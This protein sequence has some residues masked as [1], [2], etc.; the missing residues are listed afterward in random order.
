MFVGFAIDPTR[1]SEPDQI[2]CFDNQLL[3]NHM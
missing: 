1:I 3:E 2:I